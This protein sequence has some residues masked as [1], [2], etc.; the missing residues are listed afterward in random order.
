MML[1]FPIRVGSSPRLQVCVGNIVVCWSGLD[2]NHGGEYA[3]FEEVVEKFIAAL[4]TCEVSPYVVLDGGNDITDK[5]LVTLRQRAADRIRRAHQAAV[6]GKQ[7]DIL[8]QLVKLVFI[9]TLDRLEVPLAQCYQEADREIAALANEWQSPVLS[10][11]S[12][13]Y[14]FDLPA[15]LLPISEFRWE[16][17]ERSGS[18]SYIPCKKY[19]TSSFCVFV[20]IQ[21]RLLPML[22]ALAGND[23]VKLRKESSVSWAQFAPADGEEPTH[24][25]GLLCWLGRFQEPPEALEAALELMA[26]LSEEKKEE[27]RK[28]L[29]VGMKEYELPA[30]CLKM[31]FIHETAP[32]FP[33]EVRKHF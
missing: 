14:I 16:A 12:D 13:F 33:A 6:E 1:S 32:P 18:R 31:F 30:S 24:L 23:Y 15:G 3:A 4:R 21:P 25:R 19:S 9:Q 26:A 11:D 27:V 10:R 2:Q 22:G 28:D 8:P 5:K 20:N 7:N 17:L 29:Y